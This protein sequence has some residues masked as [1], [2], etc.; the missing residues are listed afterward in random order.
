MKIIL[1][2]Q[3]RKNHVLDVSKHGDI[4]RINGVDY[5]LS[6]IPEGATLPRA[7]QATGCDLFSGDISRIDGVLHISL[8][9]PHGDLPQP[10]SVLFPEPI[11][12]TAD[13]PV[14]LPY[15]N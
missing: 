4:L 9:L 14:E 11:H 15:D 12:V 3:G 1:S 10:E 7:Q 8:I 5:D 6:A 13:G 2:P